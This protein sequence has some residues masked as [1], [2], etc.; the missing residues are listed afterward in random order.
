M[1]ACGIYKIQSRHKPERIY[2]GSSVDIKSRWRIHRSDLK[3]NRHGNPKLL[4][5]CLKYGIRDLLF[6]ILITCD[7][8][9]LLDQEQFFIDA[10]NP[11]FN[12]RNTAKSN[13]GLKH[14]EEAKVKMRHP[15]SEET[16][17][18]MSLARMGNKNMQGKHHTK[19]WR[20]K[21]SEDMKGRPTWNKGTK[22][23]LTSWNKTPISQYDKQGNFIKNWDCAMY[24]EHEL[25]LSYGNI[26]K[27]LKGYRKTAGGYAWKYKNVA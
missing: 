12:V 22:G 7:E 25:N 11:W 27:V 13:L 2:I 21:H 10:Y 17:R 5:H 15:L 3:Y 8:L 20:K 23:L 18:R 26:C 24:A 14:S 1:K 16:K 4:R 9:E 19:E 6:S